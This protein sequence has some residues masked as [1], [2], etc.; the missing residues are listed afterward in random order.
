[1]NGRRVFFFP[2]TVAV[3]SPKDWITGNGRREPPGWDKDR[4]AIRL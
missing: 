1:M 4:A 3:L 2:F